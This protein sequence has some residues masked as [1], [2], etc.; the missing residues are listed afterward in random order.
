MSQHQLKTRSPIPSSTTSMS[1]TVARSILAS[2]TIW[3]TTTS[4]LL[5]PL[6][7]SPTPNSLMTSTVL[8]FGLIME[9]MPQRQRRI[10]LVARPSLV[11]PSST[12]LP[13]GTL[14]S[15][16]FVSACMVSS[17]PPLL[18]FLTLFIT[19]NNTLPSIDPPTPKLPARSPGPQCPQRSL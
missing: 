19:L 7:S 12:G 6:S 8:P 10:R 4:G 16:T 5:G 9:L 17:T 1:T 15:S 13:A 14:L 11:L 18:M 3:V 2:T